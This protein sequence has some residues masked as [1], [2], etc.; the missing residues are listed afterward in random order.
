MSDKNQIKEL[1]GAAE[2]ESSIQRVADKIDQSFE[3]SFESPLLVICVLK[4]AFVFAADL[5]RRMSLPCEIEFVRLSSYGASTESSGKIDFVESIKV[6][7]K[8]R[9]VLV[10]E[11]IVDTGLTMTA[12]R[13]DLRE[14]GAK[15]VSIASFL[16]KK[17]RREVPLDVDFKAFDVGD[18][19]VVG[20]GLDFDQRYR[21]LPF[22]GVV[23]PQDEL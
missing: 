17:A 5:V 19:F 3:A 20:Y 6:D 12:L 23:S 14:R 22:V 8:G 11:D 10:V 9:E 1:I 18:E 16:D 21:E 2:I 4:G 7:V 15:R 13:K